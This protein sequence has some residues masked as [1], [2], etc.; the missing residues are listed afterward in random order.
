MDD[1]HSTQEDTSLSVPAPGV[2]GNDSDPE[3]EPLTAAVATGPAHGTVVMAADGSFTF[4]PEP[5]YPDPAWRDDSFTYTASD[6]KATTTAQVRIRS[7]ASMT[8]PERQT[9][10]T[11]P[12]PTCRSVFRN[13]GCWPTTTTPRA[14][15]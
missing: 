10:A 8:T 12:S 4:T 1:A 14:P 7:L 6:G 5:D 9:T 15:T 13:P 2:L 3:G 11:E